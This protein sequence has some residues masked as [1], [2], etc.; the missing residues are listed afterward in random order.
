MLRLAG[1][2]AI[3]EGVANLQL[4][5]RNVELLEGVTTGNFDA[6]LS[7]WGL[8]YF[9]SPVTVLS[10]ARRAMVPGGVLVAAVWAEPEKVQFFTLPRSVLGRLVSL[11]PL[12][13]NVPGMFRYADVG[14]LEQDFIAAGFNI[15]H[16]EEME[17]E[18]MEADSDAELI[19]WTR[20]FV[21]RQPLSELPVETQ[22]LWER[23]LLKETNSFR[24]HG[25][26]RLSGTTR[27]VV[28]ASAE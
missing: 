2:R 12:D 4:C 14:R 27:I 11:P 19:A 26:V 7:R 17:V 23:E 15:Q 28:A 3:R 25:T 1:E 22:Q 10:A 24:K 8:M 5:E 13:M 6:T 21:L 18:V 16:I 20:A 9:E